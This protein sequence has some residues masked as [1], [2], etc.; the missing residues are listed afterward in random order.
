M[1]YSNSFQISW[2]ISKISYP[3]WLYPKTNSTPGQRSPWEFLKSETKE[4]LKAYDNIIGTFS[5]VKLIL[6]YSNGI[7]QKLNLP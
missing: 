3:Y 4:I 6:K 1:E 7:V 5:K 2:K